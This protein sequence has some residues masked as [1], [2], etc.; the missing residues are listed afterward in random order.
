MQ[1]GY[2]YS[3]FMR[4]KKGNV[5]KV[6]GYYTLLNTARAPRSKEVGRGD[7]L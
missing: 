7:Y 6:S 5:Y 2:K 1:N 3:L 4:K